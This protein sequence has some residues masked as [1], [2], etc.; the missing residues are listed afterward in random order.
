ME[1]RIAETILPTGSHWQCRSK[2]AG[3][4]WMQRID[5]VTVQLNNYDG[6]IFLHSVKTAHRAV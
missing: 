6:I 3:G 2:A 5:L 4:K 1:N